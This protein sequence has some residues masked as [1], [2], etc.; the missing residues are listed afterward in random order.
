VTLRALIVAAVLSFMAHASIG[1]AGLDESVTEAR[2]KAT[3]LYYLAVFVDWPQGAV[4]PGAFQI[5]VAGST[6]VFGEL[7]ANQGELVRDR[8]LAVREVRDG[9]SPDGC[10]VLFIADRTGRRVTSLLGTVQGSSVLTVGEE[11][12]FMERGGMMRIFVERSR[13]RF[14]LDLA[15]TDRARLRIPSK[16]L[17]LAASIRRDGHVVKH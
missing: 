1:E 8:S 10:H 12:R 2:A 4:D 9:E 11:D 14:E 17:G 16:M 6:P 13:M 7:K 15:R 5:C 3:F